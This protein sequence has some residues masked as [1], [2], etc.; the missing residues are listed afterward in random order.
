MGDLRPADLADWRD[1]RLLEVKSASVK[2]EMEQISAV[3]TQCVKEWG[4]LSE[5]PMAKFRRAKDSP[6]RDRLPT[7]S[8]IEALRISAGENLDNATAR[9]FHAF[10][11]ACET[12]MRA[13]EIAGLT[14]DDINLSER[15][16][17]LSMTKNG[18]ARDVP[19]TPEAVA[20]LE[21]LPRGLHPGAFGLTSP[22]ITAL[23]AKV[24]KRAGI[25]DLRFH[26]SR[27]EGTTR[28]SRKVDVLTLARITGHRDLRMLS[29]YYRETAASIAK[30]LD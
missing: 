6:P 26:D 5:N 8:E 20:L 19:L 21:A 28:L 13:G 4:L 3:L 25:V 29:R 10:L 2:R 9:T 12:A 15:V 14:W 11:F 27:A 1:R 7:A 22:Q 16:A 30:R 23:F 24:R 18:T 17:H